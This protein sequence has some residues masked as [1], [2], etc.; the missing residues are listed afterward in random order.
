M[1][2]IYTLK[3]RDSWTTAQYYILLNFQTQL[4]M[5]QN[6]KI[7]ASSWSVKPVLS[8]FVQHL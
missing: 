8:L 4:L 5:Q 3:S 2:K 1:S 6:P 7:S